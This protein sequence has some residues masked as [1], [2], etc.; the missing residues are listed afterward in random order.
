MKHSIGLNWLRR[1]D[2]HV[3]TPTLII[4]SDPGTGTGGFYASPYSK[5]IVH[6]GILIPASRN[7]T[8]V[9]INFDEVYWDHAATIAHEWRHHHQYWRGQKAVLSSLRQDGEEYE[10]HI[11]RYFADS[12]TEYDALRFECRVA[13]ERENLWRKANVDHFMKTGQIIEWNG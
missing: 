8:L 13:P 9:C 7:G 12:W 2:R 11:A 10:T 4:T 5:D 3:P 6:R 1:K